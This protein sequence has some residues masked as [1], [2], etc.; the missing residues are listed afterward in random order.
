M[1]AVRYTGDNGGSGQCDRTI[2]PLGFSALALSAFGSASDSPIERCIL[3]V[4]DWN[5]S[6]LPALLSLS[7]SLAHS[8]R[9]LLHV[10]EFYYLTDYNLQFSWQASA[11][12]Y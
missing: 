10:W 8:S 12:L 2:W 5:F 9:V 4:P 6:C 1:V 7:Q 11:E 3:S